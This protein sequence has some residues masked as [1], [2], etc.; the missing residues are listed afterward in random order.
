MTD[1]RPLW[2]D[3][4][5]DL[6][7]WWGW[8]A[9]KLTGIQV[10]T[11][12]LLIGIRGVAP[13]ASATHRV[14][15]RPAYDDSYIYIDPASALP[16]WLFAGATHSYQRDSRLSPDR[17]GDGRGDV[18]MIRPG[19]YVLTLA[20]EKPYPIFT[21]TTPGGSGNIPAY[22][23]L[24]HNGEI[25][26]DER[27]IAEDARAGNQV[28][29]TGFYSTA[30]L[31]HTGWNAPPD[32][33]HRSSI[34]CLTMDAHDLKSVAGLAKRAGGKIDLRLLEADEAIEIMKLSPYAL[35]Q[36]ERLA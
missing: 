4:A 28:N 7:L 33:E 10:L 8:F 15:A 35:K 26:D 2:P 21:V 29:L 23:D 18:G 32:S 34:S 31:L 3:D 19:A 14:T 11:R 5:A 27:R 20:I 1:A 25:S 16:P 6:R 22:S 30:V 12:P 24:D 17:D 13:N 9:G 36:P